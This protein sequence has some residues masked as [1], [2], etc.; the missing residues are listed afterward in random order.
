[1]IKQVVEVMTDYEK[2]DRLVHYLKNYQAEGSKVLI[3]VETKKGCDQLTRSL[4][5]QGQECR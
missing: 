3:F 4:R 1:M 5:H 2:F